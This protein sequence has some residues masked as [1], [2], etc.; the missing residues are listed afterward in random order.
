MGANIGVAT[1]YFKFLYP[2][3]RITSYEPDSKTFELLQKNIIGENLPSVIAI[4]KA[5]GEANGNV[6]FWTDV[7]TPGS[8]INGRRKNGSKKILVQSIDILDEINGKID[9]LKMDIEGAE[10]LVLPRLL[11]SEKSITVREMIIE[12][13]HNSF[14]EERSE[15]GKFLETIEGAGYKYQITTNS[16]VIQNKNCPQDI[17]IRAWRE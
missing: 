6:F 9:L 5:I 10:K 11:L 13:H 12:Y 2:K 17:L 3:A 8:L 4:N 7:K 15:F 1:L 14:P 16:F